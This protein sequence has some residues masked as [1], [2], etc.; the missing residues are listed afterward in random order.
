MCEWGES[1][2]CYVKVPAR[3]SHTGKDRWK[4]VGVDRCIVGLVRALNRAKVYTSGC[5]CGHGKGGGKIMLHNGRV[6][7]VGKL[8]GCLVVGKGVEV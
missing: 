7:D 6:L 2:L 3:L 4:R 8:D 5:C 1:E